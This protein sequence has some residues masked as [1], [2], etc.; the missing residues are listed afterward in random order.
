MGQI[1]YTYYL[2]YFSQQ[3]GKLDILI[4]YLTHEASEDQK[5]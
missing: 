2:I 4:F 5:T 1:L 3:A